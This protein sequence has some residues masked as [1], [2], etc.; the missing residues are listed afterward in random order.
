M[1]PPLPYYSHKNPLKYVSGMGVVWVAGGPTSLGVPGI[2]LDKYV[3]YQYD[4]INIYTYNYI[5]IYICVCVL[6]KS[7]SHQDLW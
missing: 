1:E 2:S 7:C 3:Y 5:Y 6:I 4:D